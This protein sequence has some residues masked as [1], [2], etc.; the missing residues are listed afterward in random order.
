MGY[1]DAMNRGVQAAVQPTAPQ[2]P[3]TTPPWEIQSMGAE[4]VIRT[5]HNF[6]LRPSYYAPAASSPSSGSTGTP[7]LSNF[8]TGFGSFSG[9]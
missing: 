6:P 3:G 4:N 8:S 1:A 9:K 7:E 5:E 2:Q